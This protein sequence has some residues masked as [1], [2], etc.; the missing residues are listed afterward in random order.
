MKNK[1]TKILTVFAVC[2]VILIA[3]G[4]FGQMQLSAGDDAGIAVRNLWIMAAVG[5]AGMAAVLG[6]SLSSET[7]DNRDVF[8]A[9]TK[10]KE[11]TNTVLIR[12]ISSTLDGIA[13]GKL[14]FKL[15]GTYEGE[16]ANIKNAL[17][18]SIIASS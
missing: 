18:S 10:Q 3:V 13:S 11:D 1:K 12:E 4:I 9:N 15:N 2:V 6:I 14:D 7:T 5:I 16:F 8:E 17:L